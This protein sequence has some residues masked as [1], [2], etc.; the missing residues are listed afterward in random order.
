[1]IIIFR[2][3]G[4]LQKRKERWLQWWWWWDLVLLTVFLYDIPIWNSFFFLM[5]IKWLLM[6]LMM[7]IGYDNFI[8]DFF[9]EWTKRRIYSFARRGKCKKKIKDK[10]LTCENDRI[11]WFC[12]CYVVVLSKHDEFLWKITLQSQFIL[13]VF[14]ILKTNFIFL[15]HLSDLLMNIGQNKKKNNKK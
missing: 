6:M 1:M 15:S 5:Y 2:L 7:M 12:C 4:K 11:I 3:G 14:I 10:I 9:Q 13:Y 8:H